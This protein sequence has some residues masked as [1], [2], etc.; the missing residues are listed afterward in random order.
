MSATESKHNQRQGLWRKRRREASHSPSPNPEEGLLALE[1]NTAGYTT[2]GKEIIPDERV[3]SYLKKIRANV[4]TSLPKKATSLALVLS[5]S[6]SE[7]IRSGEVQL[8][9]YIKENLEVDDISLSKPTL[10]NVDQ[11]MTIY[12]NSI[13]VAMASVFVAFTLNAKLNNLLSKESYTLKSPNYQLRFLFPCK[14][15]TINKET[16]L[17]NIAEYYMLRDFD[18]TLPY[19]YFYTDIDLV[20]IR[21]DFNSVFHFFVAALDKNTTAL[22][23]GRSKPQIEQPMYI[24]VIDKAK[25]YDPPKINKDL[26]EKSYHDNL[27]YI[28]SSSSLKNEE[29]RDEN[30]SQELL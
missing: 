5:M 7:Y 26:L 1:N 15:D 14:E 9:Q 19:R 4:K 6:E 18:N 27:A 2:K 3:I 23:Q 30:I 21:G 24:D 17:Q 12:G 13:T 20:R 22:K 16:E 28:Y 11:F 25:L 8:F 29:G 10:G